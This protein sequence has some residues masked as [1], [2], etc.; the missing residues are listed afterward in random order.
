MKQ[1]ELFALE[2]QISETQNQCSPKEQVNS[3]E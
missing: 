1:S 2:T 3:F